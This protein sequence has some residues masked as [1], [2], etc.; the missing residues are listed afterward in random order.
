[1]LREWSLI[2]AA[3]SLEGVTSFAMPADTLKDLN[4]RAVRV[5]EP[6]KIDGI[7]DEPLYREPGFSRF[8]QRNPNENGPPSE[9]TEVW[10]GYDDGALYIG[11]RMSDTA[12][13][14]IEKRLARKDASILA[15]AITF[16]VDGYHDK[17]SGFYFGI[18]AAG[19]M[20]DGVLYN[21]D[22]DDD[23]W[24]GIWEG[25]AHIDGQGWT[26]ELRIP[27]SQIRFNQGDTNRWAVDFKRIIAR[28]NETDYITFTPKNGS[29]FVSRFSDLT[30][31]DN[32]I[33]PR[34]LEVMPYITGKA[35][36]GPHDPGD[37]FHSGSRYSP[38]LGADFK[39]GIGSN[40]TIDG[41][42][43][44]DFGQVEVDPAVVNL[45]DVETYFNEKRP[46]FLEGSNIFNF[47]R[48]GASNNWSFNWS[49]PT[50]F[51][52]R[53]IGRAPQGSVSNA[54]YVDIP[55]G[56]SILGAAKVSGKTGNNWSIGAI[57][58]VTAR[59]NADIEAGGAR[60]QTEVEPL[61]YYGVVRT[62]KEINEGRQGIGLMS[63]YVQRDF[64]DPAL[65]DQI[66]NNAVMGGIDGWTAFDS[67]KTWVLT[68]WG[69][70]TNVTGNPTRI[71]ALQKSSQHYFQRPDAPYVHLDT[72]ATSISGYAGRLF[73]TKQKGN[74]TVNG[75]LGVISPGFDVNDMGFQWRTDYINEHIGAR[76][77][78]TVPTSWYNFLEF[79]AALF[80]SEDFG[81]APVWRGIWQNADIVFPNFYEFGWSY[82]YNPQT[83][84]DRKTRGGPK[85]ITPLGY[86]ISW[87]LSGDSRASFIPGLNFDTYQGRHTSTYSFS[88][89]LDWK[90]ASNIE[91]ILS[92]ELDEDWEYA[93]WVGA[94]SDPLATETHGNRYVYGEMTQKQW[95][96]GIRLNW[97]FTPTMSL[98]LYA[99]PLLSAGE[100]SNFKELARP[101]SYEFNT[102]GSGS[103]IS[104][105]T[106][107]YTV[108]PDGP[109]P[110]GT[111]GFRNPDFNVKS[112]R[113]NAVLRWEFVPGST[114]YFVWTQTRENDI[115]PGEIRLK[116]NL[117]D[118]FRSEPANIFLMKIAY[119]MNP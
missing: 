35:E 110:A 44:P 8:T 34:R 36:Y 81:G 22:W 119:W 111:F 76:Y 3:V 15:D 103:T 65:R 23:S 16:Y 79:S 11:A 39:M 117:S 94:F 67:D 88:V 19:T 51:Y 73:L 55:T 5:L 108:D 75:S 9:R 33:P 87:W 26:A 78:W 93:Q 29:G 85:V 89:N 74:F 68:L 100:F 99:Q 31:I 59:E 70:A 77:G 71:F 95:V 7:L 98:Q 43:N 18:N 10:V 20:Y 69:G 61:S 4:I 6:I 41:A 32:I 106:S 14:S 83:V 21:D 46:F 63:T 52:S 91:V 30:G 42:I 104:Y 116:Q 38:G 17:R 118:L 54:D 82:A 53:R 101:G 66:N 37:P 96:A 84:S 107:R 114:F 80:Q 105:D 57:S 112:I 1:M 2:A 40:I 58:A 102:Y 50:F 47:G 64:S 92:P 45:S 25:K 12:P 13:D 90:P 60:S 97:S 115:N 24:D 27:Y 86:E 109:G 49:N 56:T 72:S 48:G 113:G 62:L 28:L